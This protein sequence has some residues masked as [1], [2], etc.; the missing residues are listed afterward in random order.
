M[1]VCVALYLYVYCTHTQPDCSDG[2]GN[3]NICCYCRDD[4]DHGRLHSVV[5]PLIRIVSFFFTTNPPWIKHNLICHHHTL[6]MYIQN[7]L[8]KCIFII[9]LYLNSVEEG[10]H[11]I[12]FR[13][14]TLLVLLLYFYISAAG[15]GCPLSWQFTTTTYLSLSC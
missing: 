13:R 3:G 1:F 5:E 4:A 6:N 11:C 14:K 10:S 12:L 7:V 2:S 9:F 8:I 15:G